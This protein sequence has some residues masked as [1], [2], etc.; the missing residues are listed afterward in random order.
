MASGKE[1]KKKEKEKEEAF[2]T[3][4]WMTGEELLDFSKLK[5]DEKMEYGQVRTVQPSH[6]ASLVKHYTVNKPTM[7]QLTVWP[8]QSMFLSYL[9]AVSH[10]ICCTEWYLS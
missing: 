1:K 3:A 8:D 2:N 5:I 7:I 4:D 6:V 10:H 9:F